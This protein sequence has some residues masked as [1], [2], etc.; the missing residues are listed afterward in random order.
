MADLK[1][2]PQ[3][4]ISLGGVID[5]FPDPTGFDFA[6]KLYVLYTT[7]GRYYFTN[8]TSVHFARARSVYSYLSSRAEI[9]QSFS[10]RKWGSFLREIRGI[11]IDLLKKLRAINAAGLAPRLR[12]ESVD[13]L[14]ARALLKK[15]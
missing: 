6:G 12:K 3:N 9:V 11:D 5:F 7:R 13:A 8:E 2:F 4:R 14:Y 10:Y 1:N 15:L